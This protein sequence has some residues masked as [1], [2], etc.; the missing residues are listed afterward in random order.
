MSEIDN[1]EKIDESADSSLAQEAAA[2]EAAAEE[3]APG[4]D[5]STDGS[6]ADAEAAAE[7][8][9]EPE[10]TADTQEGA[11]ADKSDLNPW[12]I[13]A[14]LV[15]LLGASVLGILLLNGL[16]H[17]TVRQI[18]AANGSSHDRALTEV[19]ERGFEAIRSFGQ[20][21]ESGEAQIPIDSALTLLLDNPDWIARHPLAPEPPPAPAPAAPEAE[22][23]G[24]EGEGASEESADAGQEAAE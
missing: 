2:E 21:E 10:P 15:A 22:D 23:D 19:R 6:G 16:Y 20:D 24:E 7:T 8:D 13:K 17:Q 18:R 9:A 5:E 3:Q 4:A 11:R 12:A 14:G 1:N